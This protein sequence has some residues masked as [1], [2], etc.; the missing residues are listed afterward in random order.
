MCVLNIKCKSPTTKCVKDYKKI[1]K[2][3]IKYNIIFIEGKFYNQLN[4]KSEQTRCNLFTIPKH[5]TAFKT[6]AS[7]RDAASMYER[8]AYIYFP[9]E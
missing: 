8:D 6:V 3:N 1:R 5:A 2:K 4:I 9:N 7:E